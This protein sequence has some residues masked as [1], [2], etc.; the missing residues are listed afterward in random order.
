MNCFLSVCDGNFEEKQV[1]NNFGEN[2]V[3]SEIFKW[4]FLSMRSF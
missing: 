1:G 3:N 2:G 4:K